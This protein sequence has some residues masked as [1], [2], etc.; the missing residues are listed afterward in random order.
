MTFGE[1]YIL[2]KR[3]R[4]SLR[5]RHSI[6]TMICIMN[7]FHDT[8]LKNLLKIKIKFHMMFYYRI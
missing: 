5:L 6:A 3:A 2:E 4:F 1:I 7:V 8:E